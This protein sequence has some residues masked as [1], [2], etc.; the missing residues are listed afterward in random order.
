MMSYEG[1]VFE[2]LGKNKVSTSL[3]RQPRIDIR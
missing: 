2:A 3:V 1:V